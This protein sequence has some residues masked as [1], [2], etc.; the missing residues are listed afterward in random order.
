M[1]EKIAELREVKFRRKRELEKQGK[2][3]GPNPD[4][5]FSCTE[6]KIYFS[7]FMLKLVRNMV[8]LTKEL[9]KDI[10]LAIGKINGEIRQLVAEFEK[11]SILVA[12]K[13]TDIKQAMKRAKDTEV[14]AWEAAYRSAKA[15][16]D[17]YRC[18]VK[19]MITQKRNEAAL[20]KLEIEKCIENETAYCDLEVNI[21]W[22]ACKKNYK[23]L[24]AL[25]P[26]S[27]DLMTIA[28]VEF[29]PV[30]I[31]NG[32]FN[33]AV[34]YVKNEKVSQSSHSGNNLLDFNHSR[35]KFANN[36][37]LTD[38]GGKYAHQR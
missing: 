27:Y 33:D 18:E 26:S 22:E 36:N 12:K 32:E 35:I 7:T 9:T 6:Q 16:Y 38:K 30:E 24:K 2:K 20:L 1:K 3:D 13:M 17:V 37:P 10:Y 29:P 5:N 14:E 8:A 21:Y 25:P 19:D 15:K 4:E 31:E 23:R 28:R 34:D 11:N